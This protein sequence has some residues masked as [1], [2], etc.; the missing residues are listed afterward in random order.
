MGKPAS[1][2]LSLLFEAQSKICFFS[3]IG[4]LLVVLVALPPSFGMLLGGTAAVATAFAAA[5]AAAR[6][7]VVLVALPAGFGM[8]LRRTAAA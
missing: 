7:V 2:G 5:L 3:W 4:G 6:L 1:C 8:L